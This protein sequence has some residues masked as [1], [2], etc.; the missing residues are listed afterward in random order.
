MIGDG[1]NTGGAFVGP[2]ADRH[3]DA[4]GHEPQEPQGEHERVPGEEDALVSVW[5]QGESYAYAAAHAER[6]DP[7]VHRRGRHGAGWRAGSRQPNQNKHTAIGGRSAA[8]FSCPKTRDSGGASE[9]QKRQCMQRAA[10]WHRTHEAKGKRLA[11][12]A[13]QAIGLVQQSVNAMTVSMNAPE[14]AAALTSL[15]PLPQL[16]QPESYTPNTLKFISRARLERRCARL[17]PD[18]FLAGG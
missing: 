5:Q 17:E 16:L 18:S 7:P 6:L 10:T 15:V 12:G 13:G 9:R 11:Q 1:G 14:A 4:L 8:R 2:E 3:H